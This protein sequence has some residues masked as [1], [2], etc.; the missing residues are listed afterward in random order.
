[1]KTRSVMESS[2]VVIDD[3]RPKTNDHEE[4]VVIVNDSPLEK[5]VETPIEG[6]FN[7]DQ[8]DTQPLDRVPLLDS[9]EPAP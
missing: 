5:V 9:N 7:L 2:N 3:N 4:K 8:K 1:M 6:T